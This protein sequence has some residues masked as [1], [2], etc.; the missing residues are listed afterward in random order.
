[1]PPIKKSYGII[2]C[3]NNH[4]NGVQLLMVKKSTTYHFCEFVAGHYRKHQ[5]SHLKKLFNN[6]TYNEK[7]DI[8]SM[9]FQN[10]WYRIYRENPDIVFINGNK[11]VWASSYLRKK[12]KFENTFLQDGG[13]KLKSL[14]ADSIN[15][16]T[17]WEFPKGRKNNN[18]YELETAIREFTEET[19]VSHNK[20]QILWNIQPHIITYTDFGT[21]YQNTYYYATAIG[22][23]EPKYKFYSQQQISEVASVRWINK[24]DLQHMKLEDLTYKRLIKWFTKITNKYKK[25]KK[26]K[27]HDKYDV[28]YL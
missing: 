16:D 24:S 28:S 11:N 20:F 19:G 25:T 10:M 23:W 21:K 17:E 2:C 12:S 7:M 26:N 27:K 6:M 13:V 15:V 1:M 18:E 3:R 9:K 5:D 8:L 22:D 4:K 14:I